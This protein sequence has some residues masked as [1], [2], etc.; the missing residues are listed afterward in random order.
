MLLPGCSDDEPAKAV[1]EV[2]QDVARPL[3]V[4]PPA[5]VAEPT[6]EVIRNEVVVPAPVQYVGD[7]KALKKRG[8]LRILIPANIGGVFYLPREGW[9]VEAQHE[10]AASFARSQGLEPE[11]VPVESFR[12]MIPALL[13]GRGDIIA[14]NLTITEARRRQIA[15]SIPL[16][17][18]RKQVLVRQGRADIGRIEDLVGKRV[19]VDRNSSFWE[20]LQGLRARHPGIEL[21]ERPPDF[22]D[23][24]ELDEVAA[25]RVDAIVRD[26]NIAT[27]Y[28]NYRDDLMVGFELPGVDDIAWGIRPKSRQLRT[29][30]N[31]FLHLEFLADAEHDRHKDGLDGIKKR[32][33]LRVLMRNNAASYF[34]HKGELLGFEYELAKAF[35][36]SHKVR[37]EVIVPD[38]H[39]QLLEWLKDGRAD[40]AAGFLEPSDELRARGFAF[41]R[42]YHFAPRHLVVHADSVVD[43]A[44]DLRGHSVTVRRSS[45]YWNDLLALQA[46]GIGFE[47]EAAPEEMETEELI[48][49]VAS[50]EI[51]ATVAD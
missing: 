22:S 3:T 27:M 26:S 33:V 28:L 12:E 49:R 51:E 1:H 9:P 17:T 6:E 48:A 42:P 7:L 23:E 13:S 11:L 25:G 39:D 21:V 34:L 5:A 10:A 47:L 45:P 43:C 19:M 40:V 15:F 35:A 44:R 41:S 2:V 38:T 46:S 24:E 30:L 32:R 8:K 4:P 29:A 16:T 18:T 14:A 37:L 50:G 36:D 31:K 20:T